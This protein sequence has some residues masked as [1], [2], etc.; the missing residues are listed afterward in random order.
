MSAERIAELMFP[1]SVNT[2]AVIVDALEREHGKGLTARQ[3]GAALLIEKQTDQF[4]AGL[5]RPGEQGKG[6]SVDGQWTKEKIRAACVEAL[7]EVT[8]N[9]ACDCKDEA[10]LLNDL[11]MDD[12]DIVETVMEI[13]QQIEWPVEFNEQECHT[14]GELVT[15]AC[16]AKGVEA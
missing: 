7:V 13:E 4:P 10:H 14:F 6:W 11:A 16:K 9:P 15:A 1:I 12:L 8:G 2:L 3:V 5:F